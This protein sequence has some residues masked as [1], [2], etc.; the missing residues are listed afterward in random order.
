M[1]R[2]LSEHYFRIIHRWPDSE[3]EF[4]RIMSFR[5][6]DNRQQHKEFDG[7][8]SKQMFLRS[9]T[10]SRKETMPHKTK[11]CFGK[12]KEKMSSMVFP[13]KKKKTKKNASVI[14]KIRD[15][16]VDS[17]YAAMAAIFHRLL[18]CTTSVDVRNQSLTE[19]CL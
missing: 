5:E 16:I 18:A 4:V 10:F 13:K 17:Y 19:N 2:H 11:K 3:A 6:T 1:H 15:K 12:V 14:R 8:A 7:Y 9:Y